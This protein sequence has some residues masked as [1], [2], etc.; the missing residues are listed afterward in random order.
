MASAEPAIPKRPADKGSPDPAAAKLVAGLQSVF[1]PDRLTS[2][3]VWVAGLLAFFLGPAGMI[4]STPI[5]ALVMS[6]VSI[7][8]WFFGG[9]LLILAD[10]LVCI[11]WG[12]MAA[13]D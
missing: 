11:I 7:P 2:K 1:A 12:V 5:G 8:I 6:V 13:R 10:W 4:Y 3:N 9:S